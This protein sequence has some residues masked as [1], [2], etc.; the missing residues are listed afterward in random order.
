MGACRGGHVDD[1]RVDGAVHGPGEVGG[2]GDVQHRLHGLLRLV[3]GRP[4]LAQGARD[5]LALVGEG[6]DVR[7]GERQRHDLLALDRGFQGAQPLLGDGLVLALDDPPVRRAVA[8]AL[9]H[10]VDRVEQV[11]VDDPGDGQVLAEGDHL[12]EAPAGLELVGERV[13]EEDGGLELVRAGLRRQVCA[14]DQRPQVGELGALGGRLRLP[15]QEGPLD[16]EDLLVLAALGLAGQ[17]DAD[18]VDAV[19]VQLQLVDR[20]GEGEVLLDLGRQRGDFHGIGRVDLP[21]IRAGPETGAFR[22]LVDGGPVAQGG[23]DAQTHVRAGDRLAAVVDHAAGDGE[24]VALDRGRGGHSVQLHVDGARVGGLGGLWGG[25]VD[26]SG[27]HGGPGQQN[28]C[29]PQPAAP[30]RCGGCPLDVCRLGH[31]LARPSKCQWSSFVRPRMVTRRAVR[32]CRALLHM[33]GAASGAP[34]AGVATNREALA[35]P[36]TYPF[37]LCRTP[38]KTIPVP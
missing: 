28:D 3:G 26:Q 13:V 35:G 32:E 15:G 19:L 29:A 12:L 10:R 36:G 21:G 25:R 18:L 30:G 5:V 22:R 6:G 23:P 33:I 34:Q 14:G 24:R 38:T 1:R 11:G 4:Q 31:A 27:E 16:T 17:R 9:G 37:L 7:I 2:R 8:I 20:D